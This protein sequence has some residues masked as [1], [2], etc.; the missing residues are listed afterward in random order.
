MGQ[1]RYISTENCLTIIAVPRL[2]YSGLVLGITE[3]SSAGKVT[4]LSFGIGAGGRGF[5][6]LE[7]T[8]RG[9]SGGTG[10]GSLEATIRFW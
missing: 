10:G 6:G 1:N 5:V 4:A 9:G 3:L 7:N 8:L 2:T